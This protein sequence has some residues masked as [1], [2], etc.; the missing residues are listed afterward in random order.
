[1]YEEEVGQSQWRQDKNV[2]RQELMTDEEMYF[3]NCA[4]DIL[5]HN[6]SSMGEHYANWE[7]IEKYYGNKQED[8]IK[9][10]NRKINIINASIEGMVSQLVDREISCVTKG[11]GPE[12]MS[13]AKTAGIGIKWILRQNK[14]N[15][16]V[17]IAERRKVKFGHY[18]YR[19][20][21]NHSY[22]G[23]FGLSEIYPIPLNKVFIDNKIKDELR[24]Q[25][26]EYIAETI[27]L[28][29][30][31]AKEVYGLEKANT[32]DYGYLEH[33]DNGVFEEA[34]SEPDDESAWVL[35]L[36]WSKYE[37][38]LRLREFSACG[39]LLYDS[40]KP[41][42][43]KDNQIDYGYE[44]KSYYKYVN[45]WYPY[46]FSTKY[47]VEGDF[48]GFG[49]GWLLLPLQKM[50]N[51]FYDK[52]SIQ[53][54][55][56][57][58]LIDKHSGVNVETFDTEDSFSPVLFDGGAVGGG[59]PVHVA[60]WGEIGPE[61]YRL[62]ENIQ[63][64]AQRVIRYSN[65][66]TGQG[67]SADTAT[68][69]AIQQQQ[70]NSH[71]SFEKGNSEL[72]LADV[73]RYAL[74][75]QMEFSKT[76]KSLRIA[77]DKEEYE[78]V[79]FRNFA[80]IPVMMPS[81]SKYQNDYRENNPDAEIPKYQILEEKGKAVTKNLDLDL[82]I[83]IGSGLPKNPAFLWSM[84][85]KLSQMLIVDTEEAQPIPK[86]AINWREFRD[87]MKTF[88]GIPINSDEEMKNYVK[89]YMDVQAQKL[90][91]AMPGTGG[92]S[93]SMPAISPGGPG[94]N[95]PAE[96]VETMG[97]TAQDNFNNPAESG[98]VRHGPGGQI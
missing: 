66:M 46:F 60:R 34:F 36:W 88:L 53:M 32:I 28:G 18:C 2:L 64:E 62:L 56:N 55:P 73:I 40:H 79:D 30:E 78:W 90:Q 58:I 95:Q 9:M 23:G 57:L 59:L 6:V 85:E 41:G 75:L 83:S 65:I 24:I 22:A 13:F 37:G 21:F 70:G 43:R 47:P 49:D 84:L 45:D 67:Q 54:R 39:V 7:E 91:S 11:V 72:V 42:T 52:I 10:P 97:L 48:Y 17:A 8:M 50:I 19:V 61:I 27:S 4:I 38:K 44:H 82:E 89:R 92:I 51:E 80:N 12:D 15:K 76:G 93:T 3:V 77:D 20:S 26:A 33:R 14:I 1:M 25:E 63:T 98:G 16:K 96:Q 94:G 5:N 71:I 31:Y 68:E 29:R 74:G 87:F 81:T 35:I 86:P 69:A